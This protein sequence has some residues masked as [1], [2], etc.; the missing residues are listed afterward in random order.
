MIAI[1]HRIRALRETRDL[2]QEQA[3]REIGSSQ[4]YLSLLET[5]KRKPSLK[6]L[7]ALARAFDCNVGDFF[8]EEV[9]LP[10]N[11][12]FSGLEEVPASPELA[13]DFKPF[14]QSALYETDVAALSL[15]D[16]YREAEE[17]GERILAQDT[18]RRL[19]RM[20]TLYE[21]QYTLKQYF[22]EKQPWATIA[23][24]ISEDRVL[25]LKVW[26]AG[27]LKAREGGKILV[28]P[29]EGRTPETGHVQT[30]LRFLGETGIKMIVLQAARREQEDFMRD[31]SLGC[32]EFDRSFWC[33]G[34]LTAHALFQILSRVD[35]SDA[36]LPSPSVIFRMG[37]L[38]DVGMLFMNLEDSRSVRNV[39]IECTRASTYSAY[40][41]GEWHLYQKHLHAVKGAQVM[42]LARWS[43]VEIHV[44]DHHH[45]PAGAGMA[46]PHLSMIRY[47]HVADVIA[48]LLIY[49]PSLGPE[50]LDLD[51]RALQAVVGGRG[52]RDIIGLVEATAKAA[53]DD[54]FNQSWSWPGYR[55]LLD[56]MV[57]S[58]GRYGRR[59]AR[60]NE[61]YPQPFWWW[62]EQNE[63]R[64]GTMLIRFF[65]RNR[66]GTGRALRSG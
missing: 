17:R 59:S 19:D 61:D 2:S 48:S 32:P 6:T 15:E 1:G 35:G 54:A 20:A 9:A 62:L 57:P 41:R 22:D 64:V 40:A 55:A 12:S 24:V 56:L 21:V 50:D 31:V 27:R 66:R 52:Y 36:D 30:A 26:E 14:Q 33:H 34:V 23:R 47:A 5:D 51:L 65:D 10:G 3:A 25:A 16:T 11:T 60:V 7:E 29:E 49:A 39:W 43:D 37:L 28:G 42:R 45:Q 13:E 4:N 58:A 8:H 63:K 44:T 18:L 46:H 38:L 53:R